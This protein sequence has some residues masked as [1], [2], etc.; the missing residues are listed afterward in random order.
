[1]GTSTTIKTATATTLTTA[2][3]SALTKRSKATSEVR[4][5]SQRELENC[6]K[7]LQ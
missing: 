2:R 1:M 6:G 4:K 7:I 5:P 3:A